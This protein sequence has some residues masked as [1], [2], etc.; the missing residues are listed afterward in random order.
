MSVHPP[1]NGGMKGRNSRKIIHHKLLNLSIAVAVSSAEGKK[2]NP[3]IALK[4]SHADPDILP[5]SALP[6]TQ[7]CFVPWITMVAFNS[8]SRRNLEIS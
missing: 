3:S 7:L 4:P 5:F 1:C 6:T 2:Q 8:F